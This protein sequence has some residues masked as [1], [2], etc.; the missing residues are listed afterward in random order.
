MKKNV[1]TILFATALALTLQ[2]Q[3]PTTHDT[4]YNRDNHYHWSEWYDTLEAFLNGQTF[5]I[6]NDGYSNHV[7]Y[8]DNI[9]YVPKMRLANYHWTDRPIPIK[10]LAVGLERPIDSIY[11]HP[12]WVD[13][14]GL[15]LPEVLP[16]YLWIGQPAEPRV[17][18]PI[19]LP[20]HSIV[21]DSSRHGDWI[22]PIDSVRWD[23][24]NYRVMLLPKNINP[25]R[26]YNKLY[27]YEGFF[28]SPIWVDTDFYIIASLFNTECRKV[29]N[30]VTQDSVRWNPYRPLMVEIDNIHWDYNTD[31]NSDETIIDHGNVQL[32]HEWSLY[33]GCPRTGRDGQPVHYYCQQG[34]GAAL[35]LFPI[36]DFKEVRVE[37]EDAAL[38]SAT[39]SG[40]YYE[41]EQVTIAAVAN[42]G[43]HFVRW[44]D[45]VTANPRTVTVHFDTHYVARFVQEQDWY[46]VRTAVNNP[47]WGY[48]TGDSL[49]HYGD[50]AVVTA[51][52][53]YNC[54][55]ERWSDGVW[56]NPRTI[57]VTSDTLL[58]AIFS[59]NSGIE[60]ANSAAFTLRPNPTRDRLTV[61]RPTAGPA[62]LEVFNAK[63]QK[64][65]TMASDQATV[66]LDVSSLVAGSYLLRVTTAEGSSVRSFV[67]GR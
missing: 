16:E 13:T 15:T 60:S 19:I 9:L 56:D 64:V 34:L 5:P 36:V 59:S 54:A 1:F 66:T 17:Y 31:P 6:R 39:G 32:E 30:E 22:Y 20:D 40:L 18:L 3:T 14:P 53:S 46:A 8:N 45:G 41:G 29:Y 28:K 51:T 38:G 57:T 63:G 37:P 11:E 61:E 44:S 67:V 26:G 25:D 7:N 49:Y 33:Y 24:A 47:D 42:P 55:F 12:D 21:Y 52:A 10:G 62:T 23:T 48:A 4:V 35:C 43:S 58:T 65:M 50:Q 27:V 2:A